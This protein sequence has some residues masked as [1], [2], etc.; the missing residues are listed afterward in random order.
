MYFIQT[1][2]NLKTYLLAAQ[3]LIRSPLHSFYSPLWSV[4]ILPTMTQE[5]TSTFVV[6]APGKAILFGEHAVVHGKHAI[7]AALS[8]RNYLLVHDS[9]ESDIITLDLPELK[10]REAFKVDQ[11]PWPPK[12]HGVAPGNDLDS[13][14][15]ASIQPFIQDKESFQQAAISAFLYLYLT[16][17]DKTTTPKSYI[18]R[19][20]LPVGAGLGSSG[21][22]SVCI[23]A[24]LLRLSGISEGKGDQVNEINS[25]AFLGEKCIHGN[26]SG[27]DNTVST[28][29]GAVLFRR[30][31]TLVPLHQFPPLKLV[32]TNTNVP[33]RTSELVAG[34]GRLKNENPL[35]MDSVF[36]AVDQLVLSAQDALTTGDIEKLSVLVRLNHGL[37]ISMGVS[38]P[39]LEEIGAVAKKLGLGNTKLTGA[40][41]GGC[42]ITLVCDPTDLHEKV[43]L[44]KK[45][46][47]G[48]EVFETLLGAPG[49]GYVDVDVSI[50][51]FSSLTSEEFE[52]LGQ[53]QYWNS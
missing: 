39:A 24:A 16:I 25:H 17:C 26:P 2:H 23:S 8:L 30:P 20:L 40:G 34:V 50:D 46:L 49:V 42:A 36:D 22:F 38:H 37:L 3:T 31:A 14:I 5:A 44:L 10:C 52:S 18:F 19:S 51:R 4:I 13:E 11:L 9:P 6:S 12:K 7:A 53:W 45:E 29:G 15:V 27:I 47:P 43:A 33:R 35:I 1:T 21:S 48:K 32:L 41:G 28:L